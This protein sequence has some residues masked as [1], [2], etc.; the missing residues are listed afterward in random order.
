MW[1][2]SPAASLIFGKGIYDNSSMI[3]PRCK[4]ENGS[5][6]ICSKC[7]F[8]I[9]HPDVNNRVKMSRPAML[10]IPTVMMSSQASTAKLTPMK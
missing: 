5:R 2:L 6:T 1:R 10:L 8:Y 4:T 3:C 7:G 9:Y